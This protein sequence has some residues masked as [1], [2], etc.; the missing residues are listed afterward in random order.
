MTKPTVILD[1]G[2]L[3]QGAS[4]GITRQIQNLG[5]DRKPAYGAGT[6]NDWQLHIEGALAEMAFAKHLGLFWSGANTFRADDVKS[7]MVRST[8]S[9]SNRLIVHEQDL[10]TKKF[11]LVTG[12]NGRYC[13][14]G[15]IRGSDAKK[16]EWWQDPQGNRPAFFVPQAALTIVIP[17]YDPDY[18]FD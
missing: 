1:E 5:K 14:Q 15:W 12:C 8:A 17:G 3:Y 7:W 10:D 18:N 13:I 2:E 16:K 11:V 6:E 9:H 4:V